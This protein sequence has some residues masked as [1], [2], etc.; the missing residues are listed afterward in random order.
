MIGD[1]ARARMCL[2]EKSLNDAVA[3]C[4][5]IGPDGRSPAGQDSGTRALAAAAGSPAARRL[6]EQIEDAFGGQ[7]TKGRPRSFSPSRWSDSTTIG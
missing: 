5:W 4:A 2:S 6:D 7:N 1:D 3:T